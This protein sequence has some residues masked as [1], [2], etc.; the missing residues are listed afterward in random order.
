MVDGKGNFDWQQTSSIEAV[1][2]NI[3]RASKAKVIHPNELNPYT[4]HK[5]QEKI[6]GPLAWNMFKKIFQNKP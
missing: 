6:T 2:L 1:L 3:N 5:H 4:A